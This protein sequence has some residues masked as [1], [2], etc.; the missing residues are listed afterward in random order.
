[1]EGK[2]NTKCE[3]DKVV[4][5]GSKRCVGEIARSTVAGEYKVKN[6]V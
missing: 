1:M 6:T 5:R 4:V 2:L 3:T